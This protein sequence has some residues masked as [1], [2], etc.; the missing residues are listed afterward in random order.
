MVNRTPA[1][2]LC[3]AWIVAWWSSYTTVGPRLKAYGLKQL[4]SAADYFFT[5]L[6][7]ELLILLFGLVVLPVLYYFLIRRLRVW[8]Q[9]LVVPALLGGFIY[10]AYFDVVKIARAAEHLCTTEAGMHIYKTVEAEGFY[11][12]ID[13]DPWLKRGFKWVEISDGPKKYLRGSMKDGRVFVEPV[14][15][16]IS[17]YEY[18]FEPIEVWKSHFERNR[19][20][21]RHR[22]SRE[23][24]GEIIY[25]HIYRGWA[26]RR[27]EFG[28]TFIPPICWDGPPPKRGGG[29]AIWS[30]EL[31]SSTIYPVGQ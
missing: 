28:L 7:P 10:L 1:L 20:V 30:D 8:L 18:A 23:V 13:I 14:M 24:L 22:E 15:T 5:Y 16:L 17:S 11:G 25:F 12:V 21:V 9:V 29:K 27:A 2:A 6:G 26:D 31:I 19:E 3:A 4:G